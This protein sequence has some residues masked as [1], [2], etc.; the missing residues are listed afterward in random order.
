[1]TDAMQITVSSEI[2]KRMEPSNSVAA[3]TA[4]EREESR[5]E[6]G[7]SDMNDLKYPDAKRRGHLLN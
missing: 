1:M 2:A 5:S 4:G 7:R 3:R 6:S